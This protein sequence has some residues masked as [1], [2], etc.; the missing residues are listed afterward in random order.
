MEKILTIVIPTYNMEKLLDKCLTSLIVNDEE[1]MNKL[2]VIVVIDGAKDRSSEIAHSYQTRFPYTFRA[3]DKENGNYGS[4]VNR[5]LSEAKGKYIKILDADDSFNNQV[6]VQ[7][8]TV[9]QNI[10]V[11]LVVNLGQN[12]D[13][14][15]N[16]VEKWRGLNYPPKQIMST[17][18][19]NGLW[20]HYIT[21]KTSILK[22]IGYR[23]TEGI[24]YTDEEWSFIPALYARTFS[25]LPIY[26]YNYVCGRE[27]QTMNKDVWC[28]SID[29]EIIVSKKMFDYW[30]KVKNSSSVN[31]HYG[32]S[33]INSHINDFFYRGLVLYT[34]F[35]N[36]DIIE[37]DKYIKIYHE[38]IYNI[39]NQCTLNRYIKYRYLEKWRDNN[40][41]VTTM[42]LIFANISKL[43][44]N[45]HSHIKK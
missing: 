24:S 31:H 21:Y 25:F 32:K 38:D 3:I 45:I 18:I 36:E 34:L 19:L 17:S 33:K 28:K 29:S 13:V 37:F 2:E 23:Q 1:L 4:C 12:V 8:L 30:D 11:D 14:S 42:H 9:L 16:I 39:T 20:I 43:L 15:G 10:D 27:G 35:D 5:G 44:K 7:Y 40:Y 41:E 22:N 6:F 26:L